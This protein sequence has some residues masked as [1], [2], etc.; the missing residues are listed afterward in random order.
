MAIQQMK[1]EIDWASIISYA[2]SVI[3]LIA[4][5]I[6]LKEHMERKRPYLK[7]SLELIRNNL[8]CLIIR[9]V[10]EVEANLNSI[11]FNNEFIKQ[12]S[13]YDPKAIEDREDLEISINPGKKWIITLGATIPDIQKYYNKKLEI[14]LSYLN[15]NKKRK[16]EEKNVVNF[17]DYG[18]FLL[19][20]SEMDELKKEITSLSTN[21]KNINSGQA[22][23]KPKD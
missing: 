15:M 7:V 21:I 4:I 16:Y 2:C 23:L 3:S 6:L 12:L 5:I 18:M 14:T 19:Y 10:G 22:F 9:N 8:A 11:K 20:I 1:S 17:N 13:E